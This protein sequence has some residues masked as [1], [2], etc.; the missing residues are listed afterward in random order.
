MFSDDQVL[1]TV[2]G[3]RFFFKGEDFNEDGIEIG[4]IWVEF[5]AGQRERSNRYVTIAEACQLARSFNSEL[6]EN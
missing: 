4:P 3:L 5:H 6:T 1:A 2:R